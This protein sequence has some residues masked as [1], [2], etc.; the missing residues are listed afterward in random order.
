GMF[1]STNNG[2]SWTAINSGLT[3]LLIKSIAIDPTNS[4]LVYI[5]TYGGGSWAAINIDLLN[6]LVNDVAIDPALNK[7]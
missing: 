2:S 4:Q 5:G 6:L 7:I 3:T 1:K